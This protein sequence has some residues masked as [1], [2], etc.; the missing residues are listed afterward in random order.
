MTLTNGLVVMPPTGSPQYVVTGTGAQTGSVNADGS[1]SF[2]SC[3]TLSL[4][5]VFTSNYDNYMIVGLHSTSADYAFRIRFRQNGTDNTTASSYT[6]Q[7]WF[8]DGSSLSAQR[9]SQDYGII[10]ARGYVQR[11]G[12]IGYI[13][14]PQQSVQ[15][16]WRS[17]M[18]DDYLSAS[19]ADYCGTHSQTV[20]YDGIT[21]IASSAGLFSGS[22]TVYGFNQ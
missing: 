10:S 12:F 14:G 22:I 19:V 6:S 20:S 3:A 1:F 11:A 7:Y 16:V 4:N 21:F 18:L 9:T 13:F 15:T 17:S 5:G 2:S 8:A